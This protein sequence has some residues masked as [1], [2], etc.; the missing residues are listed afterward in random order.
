MQSTGTL[1][2][3]VD[4]IEN[5]TGKGGTNMLN[6]AAFMRFGMLQTALYPFTGYLDEIQIASSVRT[7]DW[8]K[9]SYMNQKES[10]VLL[11][12]H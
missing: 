4:G 1:K 9:L 10:D 3:F 2:L 6:S 5:A 11:Q 12:F 7:A 8:V